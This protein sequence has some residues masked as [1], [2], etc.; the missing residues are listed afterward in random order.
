MLM[1][2]PD[3]KSDAALKLH[4]LI[5]AIAF[6]VLLLGFSDALRELVYR[7]NQQE[8]YS[9][10]FLIPVVAAWLLWMRRD[11]LR[12][13]VGQTSFLGVALIILAIAMN[14]LGTLS[15]IFILSQVGFV[16]ALVG[17]VL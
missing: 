16:V 3:R 13:S 17:L 6:V 10:G 1:A 5:A 14:V 8:E 11:A 4:A 12:A 9:H 2:L 7:W 15:A